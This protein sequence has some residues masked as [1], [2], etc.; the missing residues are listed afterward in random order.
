MAGVRGIGRIYFFIFTF[1]ERATFLLY[2]FFSRD[3]KMSRER[4][5]FFLLKKCVGKKKRN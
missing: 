4:P 2:V 5:S 1:L 3:K